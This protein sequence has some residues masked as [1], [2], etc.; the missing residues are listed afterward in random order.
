[1]RGWTLQSL[2]AILLLTLLTKFLPLSINKTKQTTGDDANLW[3]KSRLLTRTF[4]EREYPVLKP[5]LLKQYT[6]KQNMS[7]DSP[8]FSLWTRTASDVVAKIINTYNV[9]QPIET[10]AI[11]DRLE[12]V[13]KRIS[14]K[15]SLTEDATQVLL[16]D[17][18]ANQGWFSIVAAARG[19]S[20]IAVEAMPENELLIKASVCE[21]G[22]QDRVVV[23]GAA[24]GNDSQTCYI[25]SPSDD[26][27][28]GMVSC[29]Y[30]ET[31]AFGRNVEILG[32]CP[33]VSM[34]H[35]QSLV[36]Q[37][38]AWRTKQ[39]GAA[40]IDVE[41]FEPM[42]LQGLSQTMAGT[43]GSKL[44]SIVIEYNPQ[45]IDR[46]DP[47]KTKKHIM[48]TDME[49]LGFSILQ[50]GFIS[51]DQIDRPF[52]PAGTVIGSEGV[53]AWEKEV[54]NLNKIPDWFLERPSK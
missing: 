5:L 14:Q 7:I 52:V 40:K 15:H 33:I 3:Q 27:G 41:G 11:L 37:D 22:F 32:T 12:N 30:V 1:M 26:R 34:D 8:S 9:W 28:N 43:F 24:A 2:F 54:G 16:L 31:D 20:A 19:Y 13:A 4:C 47:S 38:T 50:G 45:M 49:A 21:N 35:L 36:H 48:L 6:L 18:G 46:I 51:Q 53:R 39:L 23:V 10:M 29:E 44:N 25:T 42:V 17:I